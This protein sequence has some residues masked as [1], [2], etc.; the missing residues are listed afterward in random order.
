MKSTGLPSRCGGSTGIPRMILGARLKS[1]VRITPCVAWFVAYRP[2]VSQVQP[3]A[4]N[5]GV[6]PS[7]SITA[8]L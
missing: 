8:T 1:T 3:E 7:P 4:R 5:S 6:P 2:N